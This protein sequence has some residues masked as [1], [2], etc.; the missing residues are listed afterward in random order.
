MMMYRTIVRTRVPTATASVS[1]WWSRTQ[2][3]TLPYQAITALNQAPAFRL[4]AASSDSG[5]WRT[6]LA[7]IIGTS[8]RET[9]AEIRIVTARVI[10]NSRNRRPTTLAMKSSG[11]NTA[12]S[13]TVREMIVKPICSEPLRAASIGD[14]PSQR[15]GRCFR[16]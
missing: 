8:V 13:E 16:S 2:L 14:G 12:M 10:A 11:I 9:T 7:H 4:Q 15:S 5:R 3:S 6:S 1:G